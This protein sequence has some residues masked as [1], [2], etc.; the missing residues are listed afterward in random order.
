MLILEHLRDLH[1]AVVVEDGHCRKAGVT[2]S[3][4]R[5]TRISVEFVILVGAR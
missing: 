4:Q 2:I 3:N 1:A 5:R